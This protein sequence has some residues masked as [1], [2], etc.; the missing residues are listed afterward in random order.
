VKGIIGLNAYQA[1]AWTTVKPN[2]TEDEV[3]NMCGLGVAGEAGE[4]ADIVKKVQHHGKTLDRDHFIEELGDVLW[5]VAVAAHAIGV[6]L[7][8]VAHFNAE[9]LAKRYPKPTECG[10]RC[11]ATGY[12]CTLPT[13]HEGQHVARAAGGVYCT[14]WQA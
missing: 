13:A 9:K 8:D 1:Q 6:T 10:E 7:A 11:G 14:S 3:L 4:V 2:M 5:Y 12:I